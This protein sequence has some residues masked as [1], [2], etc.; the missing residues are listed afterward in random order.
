MESTSVIHHSGSKVYYRERGLFTVA[1]TSVQPEWIGKWDFCSIGNP[2]I[3]RC[4]WK[5][6]PQPFP[7]Q[8][9]SV[10]I[11]YFVSV[12][13]CARRWNSNKNTKR[14]NKLQNLEQ[15]AGKRFSQII[16]FCKMF[17]FWQSHT[18]GGCKLFC[19]RLLNLQQ[20]VVEAEV[21]R[22]VGGNV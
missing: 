9:I 17:L 5:S 10:N 12:V 8:K 22:C 21:R 14:W 2:V 20:V 19:W 4:V 15:H 1:L 13:P 11:K 18:F 7:P 16:A 3:S 6:A